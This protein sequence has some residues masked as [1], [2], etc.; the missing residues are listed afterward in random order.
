M[1]SVEGDVLIRDA[2]LVNP[3]LPPEVTERGWLLIEGPLIRA[4]GSGDPPGDLRARKKTLNAH[5]GIL[6]PGLVNLHTHAAMSLFR[7]LADDMPLKEWLE[8][9]IFP[10]EAKAVNE[11]FVYWGTLLSCCEMIFSGTTTFADGYF[12]EDMVL[13]GAL[14]SGMRATVAQGVVDFPAPGCPDPSLNIENA[15]AFINRSRGEDSVRPGIFCH[16]AYTCSPE[17]IQKAKE[18]CRVHG[19]PF[20]I[21]VSET[22]WE[23]QEIKARYG[24]RPIEHLMGLGVLDRGT[25]LVHGVWLEPEEMEMIAQSGAALVTCTESNMKLG[26]G[27]APLPELLRRGVRV[28]IGTDGPAS[29]NDLD[30]FGEMD[31]TAKIHKVASS[32]P[33]AVDASIVLHMATRGGATILGFHDVGL[34]EPGFQADLILVDTQKPHMQPLYHPVSQL[35]YAAKGSDVRSVWIKGRQIME[36]RQILTMEVEEVIRKARE[37]AKGLSGART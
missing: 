11:E 20:F 33:T 23:V 26:A 6:M 16:S 32:D 18:V 19:V 28:G 9:H 25:I 1:E 3:T 27:I 22:L 4:M 29:N 2:I 36:E 35:V 17:T 7:G 15:I 13:E 8:E 37:L 31:L 24:L 34:L 30:L 5:G 10:A 21:H 12:Y 14:L